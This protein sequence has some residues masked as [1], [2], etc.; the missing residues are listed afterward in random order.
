MGNVTLATSAR[1]SIG[2]QHVPRVSAG[3]SEDRHRRASGT[4]G[5]S[6]VG[7]VGKGRNEVVEDSDRAAEVT[8][9][10]PGQIRMKSYGERAGGSTRA[11]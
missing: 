10:A 5:P 8:L 6:N 4:I 11:W 9:S 1:I 2:R 7:D 3:V